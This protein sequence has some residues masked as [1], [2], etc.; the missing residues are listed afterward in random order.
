MAARWIEAD[1][2]DYPFNLAAIESS[3][4]EDWATRWQEI[5]A[6]VAC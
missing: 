1:N 5:A 2:V 6:N 4:V 3:T